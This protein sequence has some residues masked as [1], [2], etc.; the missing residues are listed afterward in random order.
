MK[1]TGAG[2]VGGVA[3]FPVTHSLS[4]L[5]HGFWLQEYD[6]NGAY[7]P[8]TIAPEDF[9]SVVPALRRAGFAG[10][11]VTVPHKE[12]AYA[13]ANTQSVGARAAGAANLLIFT[14][15]GIHADNTDAPG[16]VGTLTA[17]LGGDGLTGKKAVILGAGGMAR[18]AVL[19]LSIMGVNEIVLI[20]RRRAAAESL[21]SALQSVC[22]A[23]IEADGF[24]GWG[25]AA[26]DCALLV[27]AT[28]AGMS[29]RPPLEISLAALPPAASVFD[30]VYNPLVT[31][32][33]ADAAARGHRTIDGL[34]L[35]L[36]QAVP[37]FEALYGIRPEISPSL[38]RMLEDM[39]DAH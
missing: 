39:L 22:T 20:A 1:L 28:S 11:N 38:R 5:L 7:V 33:L 9:C 27:N 26:A 17:A 3:G 21:A 6:V 8:L 15:N 32:L 10:I 12:T 4:P 30:A 13:L 2:K 23:Q 16:L 37:T 24:D 34:W 29:G 25:R 14:D 35:L 36:H 31:P 19:A 18:A